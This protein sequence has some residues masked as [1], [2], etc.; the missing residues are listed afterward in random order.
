MPTPVSLAR[1][2]LTDE[3]ARALDD[4][5]AV[6]RRRCHTQTTSLHA[7]SALLA[8]PSSSLREACS[9]SRSSA[10]S[11]RLQFRALELCV[12]VSLDRLPSSKTAEDPP[13]SNSLMA[14]IKRSQ[15][16]QRRHPDS[17]H[18]HMQQQ[19]QQQTTSISCVKVELKHFI[20]SIL[21]DP[22]VSKV[23]GEAG[24]RSYD[25]KLAIL[26]PPAPPVSRFSRS[27]CPPLFLCNLPGG[28]SDPGNFGFPFPFTGPSGS[29]DGDENCRRIGEILVKSKGKNPLLI[30]VC[31]SDALNSFAE[32]VENSSI[33]PAQ[34]AGLKLICIKKE[35]SEFVAGGGSED[36]LDF[37]FKELGIKLEHH[38]GPGLLLSFGELAALVGDDASADALSRVVSK[39]TGLLELHSE[40]LRLIGAAESYETYLKFLNRFPRIEKDWDLHLL[41]ITSSSRPSSIEGFGSKSSLMGSFVPFGGFF[42]ASSDFKNPLSSGIQSESRCHLCNEKY[43][44]E[45]YAILKGGSGISVS[46]QCSATIP[47]WLQM[48]EQSTTKG[49]DAAKVQ[50]GGLALNAKIMDLQKKWNDNCQRLRHPKPFPKLH[51]SQARSQVIGA[52]GF[53]FAADKKQSSI[54]DSSLEE[55]GCSSTSP[56]M[57]MDLNK[58][59]S[60]MQYMPIQ[61][62]SE[63]ANANFQSKLQAKVLESWRTETGNFWFQ[64]K[65]PPDLTRLTNHTPSSSVASVATDLQLGTPYASARQEKKNLE[66]QGH[67]NHLQH[68]PGYVSAAF[69]V[70]SD[71]SSKR[72]AQSSS[73]SVPELVGQLDPSDLKSLWRVLSEK[74][75]RQDEAICAICQ[76]ISRCRT[77]D[78][79]HHGSSFKGD[80]WFSFL[81][82]D[83]L[84]KKRVATALAEVMFGC[85]ESLISVD[86]NSQDGLC[87]S[88]S[89]FD[90]QELN[91]SHVKFRGKTVVDYIAEELRKKPRSL[92]FLENV[93]KADMLAQTSLSQ[94]V[95]TSK[96][97]DSHGREISINN[98]IFVTTSSITNSNNNYNNLLSWEKPS[99]F[100]EERILRAN[101]WQLQLLVGCVSRDAAR[102]TSGMNVL[103]SPSEGTS[104]KA[105]LRKRKLL[106][107][108]DSAEHDEGLEVLKRAGKMSKSCLDLNLPVEEMGE[109]VDTGNSDSS[110]CPS[111]NPETWLED[112]LNQVDEQVVFKPFDFDALSEKILEEISI[113]FQKKV[114]NE[115]LLEIDPQVMVQ[116]LAAAWVSSG[117]RAVEDWVEQ[118]LSRSFAEAR[119]RYDI[120]SRSVLKLVACEGLSAEERFPGVCLPVRIILN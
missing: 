119:Q 73:C 53:Q 21:D 104:N 86:L 95:R 78:R 67:I 29:V 44:Q 71:N 3:A 1:Q 64:P 33:L 83:K 36:Q 68:F 20:L 103:V 8:L 120:A 23:F 46:D 109:D 98:M 56:C 88:N 28:D 25:I 91:V 22:I 89:I 84:G 65:P 113:S 81:G 114:G 118:V 92:I 80:I 100:S 6:A 69:D 49:A 5:V 94:A 70:V 52:E 115:A 32:C 79:R 39:L 48:F 16:N 85:T 99:E 96:F 102:N 18:L 116:I 61:I 112:F 41:P 14:A 38:S 40:N 2:C 13:V 24:F 111:E 62:Y 4:A 47:S 59:S 12:G 54:K 82:P 93:D 108:S 66:F 117:K 74:V 63:A 19:Q 7:V 11:P 87:Q 90:G 77:G 55:S 106:K 15:A 35:V 27:R 9:R 72:T 107:T 76:T 10:Y 105:L 51:I 17:F 58:I 37:R 45:A 60:S 26:Q 50:D 110:D 101:G 57:P 42:S 75:G 43:E 30:G 34:L 97:P 31:A